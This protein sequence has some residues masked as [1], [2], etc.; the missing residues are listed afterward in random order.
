MSVITSLSKCRFVPDQSAT[1]HAS[2][3][4]GQ[5]LSISSYSS[6]ALRNR[7]IQ[8]T[9]AHL[10]FQLYHYIL[11]HTPHITILFLIHNGRHNRIR[12]F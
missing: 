10:F 7:A 3:R 11:H 2:A 9:H 1:S 12:A 5:L 8:H 4:F 6:A